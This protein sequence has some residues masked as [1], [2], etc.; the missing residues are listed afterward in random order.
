MTTYH[1]RL[2]YDSDGADKRAN[3]RSGDAGNRTLLFDSKVIGVD[4]VVFPD[5]SGRSNV[6]HGQVRYRPS[7]EPAADVTVRLGLQGDTSTRTDAHGQ[8]SAL[9]PRSEQ[10]LVITVLDDGVEVVCAVPCEAEQ[11]S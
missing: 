2:L 11:E 4:M 5:A 10:P 9:L 7:D 1:A 8:F 6:I 3:H